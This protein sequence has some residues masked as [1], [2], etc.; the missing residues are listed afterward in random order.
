MERQENNI[1]EEEEASEYDSFFVHQKFLLLVFT[2]IYHRLSLTLRC[3]QMYSAAHPRIVV[4][5]S[6]LE[7][8]VKQP[9]GIRMV[10]VVQHCS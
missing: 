9:V 7:I 2:N 5:N 10:P 8:T 3:V 4:L 1:E 6:V